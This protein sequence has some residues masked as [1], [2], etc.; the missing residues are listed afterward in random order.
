VKYTTAF[1]ARD[2]GPEKEV[3][4]AD[5]GGGEEGR[6]DAIFLRSFKETI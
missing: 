4:R 6:W 1:C 3:L 5:K 2:E